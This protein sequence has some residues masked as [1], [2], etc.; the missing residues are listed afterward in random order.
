MTTIATKS[1]LSLI[2]F[3]LEKLSGGVEDFTEI[4]CIQFAT[5]VI[6][7]VVQGVGNWCG[8]GGGGFIVFVLVLVL[9]GL[10]AVRVV[11]ARVGSRRLLVVGGG[12]FFLVFFF[13]TIG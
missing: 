6:G 13:R 8:G 1:F 2:L 4:S 10:V 5:I 12:R 7:G 3:S 11:F 9:S